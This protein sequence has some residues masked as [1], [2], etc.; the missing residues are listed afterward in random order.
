ML[1]VLINFGFIKIYTFGFFLVLG[2]FWGLFL[3]WKNIRLTSFK[4]EEI[5]D[6]V[7]LSI[8]SG[9]FFSR[10]F[11]VIL[12]FSDFG[13]NILKFILIN[14]YPGLSIYGFIFG[15]FIFSFYYL[16]SKKINFFQAVDYFISPLFLV[17][18]LGKI[19]SFFS[20]EEVGTITT[21]FLKT[22]YLGFSGDRHLTAV[23]EGILFFFGC[24]L[25]QKLVFEIRKE[26]LFNGFLFVF[27]LWY[28]SL[29]YLIFD[30]LKE[31]K[32]YLLKTSFNYL[33]SLVLFLTTTSYFVYYFRKQ[34]MG[35]IKNYGKKIIKT[36]NQGFKRKTN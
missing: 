22:K 32:F 14:G 1:P 21:F 20:G 17:L 12:N 33:V 11:Y 29:V 13:F 2:F 10:L 24:Y 16:S 7:F 25:A 35:G 26:R 15:F 4:E 6:T 3:L 30:R 8:I 18:T 19:G 5:F 27:S 36:V 34:I 23:Y 9:L 31:I 28:F